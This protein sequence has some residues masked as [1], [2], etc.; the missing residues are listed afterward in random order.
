MFHRKRN[1]EHAKASRQRKKVLTNNLLQCVEDLKQETETLR[2]QLY[3]AVGKEKVLSI[4]NAT[5]VEGQ[6]RFLAAIKKPEN[7]VVDASTLR[8][9]RSLRKRLPKET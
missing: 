3:A 2:N 4:L 7:R 1:R 8:Y 9:L 5:K 6:Q